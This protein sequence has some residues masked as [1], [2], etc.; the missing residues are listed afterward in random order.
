LFL[1]TYPNRKR[2]CEEHSDVAIPDYVD[3]LA[4]YTIAILATNVLFINL[5]NE[6]ISMHKPGA[7]YQHQNYVKG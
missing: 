7:G 3:G 6:N 1:K 4:K 5:Q 2:H